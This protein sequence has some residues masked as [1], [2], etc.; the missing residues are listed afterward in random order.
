MIKLNSTKMKIILLKKIYIPFCLKFDEVFARKIFYKKI[1]KNFNLLEEDVFGASD[2]READHL[3]SCNSELIIEKLISNHRIRFLGVW[4]GKIFSKN[5]LAQS[6]TRQT[7]KILISFEYAKKVIKENN[8]KGIVYIWP[9]NFSWSLYKSMRKM[10]LLPDEIRI[11]PLAI[12]YL[13]F[14]S[15]FR[16]LYFFVKS[17]AY[18]E[19]IFTD[20]Y[21]KPHK[22]THEFQSAVH[23]D[24]GAFD[25]SQPF[26]D[27]KIFKLFDRNILLINEEEKKQQWEIQ[28]A[29]SDYNSFHLPKITKFISKINYLKKFY[30]SHFIFRNK[31]IQLSLYYPYLM[32][33]SYNSLRQRI[34]WELFYDQFTLK[35][36]TRLMIAEN[37]TSSIVHRKHSVDTIFVYFSTTESVVRQRQKKEKSS[38]NEYAY[39]ISD[40]SVSSRLSNKFISSMECSISS[41][42]D[43]GPVFRDICK[44]TTAQK[45]EL[46]NILKIDDDSEI[47]SF[48]DHTIGHIGVLNKLAYKTFLKTILLCAKNNPNSIFLF[49]SK[50]AP[51]NLNQLSGFDVSEIIERIRARDNCIYANDLNLTPYQLIGLSDLII[52]APM[53]SVIFEALSSGKPAISFDPE[54][55]YKRFNVPSHQIPNLSVYSIDELTYNIKTW[56]DDINNTKFKSFLNKYLQSYIDINENES[57]INKFQSFLRNPDE[58]EHGR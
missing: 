37:I 45:E 56:Q 44:I 13:I 24:D 34:L 8:I 15:G 41:F 53:S 57:S 20:I 55:Q 46:L 14:N 4:G 3:A 42:V 28:A 49:K 50:K 27:N 48:F 1:F 6:I 23:I 21:K 43:I 2:Y 29:S 51:E 32:Q 52:S 36:I 58:F 11:Y 35:N 47:I 9:E 31:L 12:I 40:Y 38:C 26:K 16:F 17:L 5:F 7:H 25:D 39:M 33:A 10:K 54:R 18:P 19:Y 30:I 22:G